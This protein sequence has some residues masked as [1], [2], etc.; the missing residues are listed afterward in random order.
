MWLTLKSLL[1]LFGI[2]HSTQKIKLLRHQ[3]QALEEMLS[4]G[5]IEEYQRYQ[6]KPV[7]NG[8]DLVA[9]FTA[10]GQGDCLFFGLYKVANHLTLNIPHPSADL[11]RFDPPAA[12]AGHYYELERVPGLE[13]LEGRLVIDWRTVGRDKAGRIWHQ[14]LDEQDKPVLELLPEGFVAEFPGFERVVLRRDELERLFNHSEARATWVWHQLMSEV[15]AIYLIVS[16]TGQQYVGSAYGEGGL[17]RRWENYARDPSGGNVILQRA[18][19]DDPRF[20][21]GLR[22]SVLQTLPHYCTKEEVIALESLYKRKLGSRAFGL[23][24]N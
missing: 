3:T 12:N 5:L 18:I 11:L 10:R 22:Y 2:S 7:L 16:A 19:E 24:A 15:A 20:V 21:E 9:S 8:A 23:N 17:W 1:P 4:Y 14:W 13:Q 6:G